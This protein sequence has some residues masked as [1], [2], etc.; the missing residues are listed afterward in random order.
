[1]AT[2]DRS[3]VRYALAVRRRDVAVFLI[4]AA[5]GIAAPSVAAA[6][7]TTALPGAAAAS[8]LG[9]VP[10]W[11]LNQ[12][13]PNSCSA[14]GSALFVPGV[15]TNIPTGQASEQAVMRGPGNPNLGFAQDT[16]FGPFVGPVGYGIGIQPYSFP[17]N[18][19]LTL[20]MTTYNGTNFTGGVSF[21]STIT[22]NCST[23]AVIPP[24]AAAPALS[25]FVL[26]LLALA[27][28]SLG[29]LRLSRR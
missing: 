9:P 15:T 13:I 11:K 18:T 16:A 1:M 7:A 3:R 2:P 28:L 12:G 19:A 17:P 6:Q 20:T 8:T 22:W 26:S 23:G 25:H 24:R 29:G 14:Q 5:C 10:S 4:L 21:I 27:L